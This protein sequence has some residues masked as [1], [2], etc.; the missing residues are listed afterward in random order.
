MGKRIRSLFEYRYQEVTMRALMD[1]LKVAAFAGHKGGSQT[2]ID[3]YGGPVW[4]VPEL[5]F[6]KKELIPLLQQ[7]LICH[8]KTFS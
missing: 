7:I 3:I 1:D 4:T 8:E 6:E 5:V 2:S